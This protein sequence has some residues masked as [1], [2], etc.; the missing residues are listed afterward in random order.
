MLKI[1]LKRKKEERPEFIRIL[2]RKKK[3]KEER[4]KKIKGEE[5]LLLSANEENTR[6]NKKCLKNH[7]NS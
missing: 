3:M 2:D 4:E 1:Y 7:R 5:G 6:K